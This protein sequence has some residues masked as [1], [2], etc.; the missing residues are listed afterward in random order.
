MRTIAH[1]LTEKEMPEMLTGVITPMLTALNEDLTLD[2]DGNRSLIEW[3][4]RTGAVTTIFVRSGTGQMFTYSYEEVETMIDLVLE[5][6]KDDLYVMPGTSG[7][8]PSGVR[9]K[10][11]NE[12]KYIQESIE[13]TRYAEKR[14]ADGVVVLPLGLSPCRNMADKILDFYRK[15][16]D[17]ANIPIVI[18]QPPGVRP[19]FSMTPP[20]LHRL[21]EL[22]NLK[23]MKFSTSDMKDFGALCGA[24]IDQDFTMISGHEGAFLS[25]LVL[26]AGAC[27]GGGCN[28]HP[29]VI[30]EIFDGFME[31]DM[32][33]AM[34]AQFKA[35]VLLSVRFGA[36]QYADV[37]LNSSKMYLARKGVKVKPFN[38]G[39]SPISQD[40]IDEIERAIDSAVSSVEP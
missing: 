30:R 7:T 28:T 2:E 16:D 3:Y 4:K 18:Y 32:M 26:G 24:V 37:A 10:R 34:R 13:L 8:F 27:I 11:P 17:A 31:G 9:E 35:I 21:A 14:G 19:P 6:A 1:P 38:R 25:S 29:E 22:E 15:V 33:R 39:K 20:L 40:K 12:S 5:E 23:G 36:S